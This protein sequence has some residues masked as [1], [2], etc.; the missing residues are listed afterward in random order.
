MPKT[1]QHARSLTFVAASLILAMASALVGASADIRAKPVT[2]LAVYDSRGALVGSVI[3]ASNQ[4]ESA[5][6]AL[7]VGTRLV[8]LFAFRNRLAD[9]PTTIGT[10][11]Y[12]ESFDCTGQPFEGHGPDF[13]GLSP[14]VLFSVVSINAG[15]LYVPSGAP[16]LHIT[17]SAREETTGVCQLIEAFE[18]TDTPL[19]LLIDL[20]A[21]FQAPFSL[22]TAGD[23]D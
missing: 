14:D 9:T 2:Q 3:D 8:S 5:L 23:R 4:P 22:G 17:N 19:A 20:Y 11:L 1:W 21:Q 16:Q 15:K 6:V 13:P 7:R 10:P 12:Y 18:S